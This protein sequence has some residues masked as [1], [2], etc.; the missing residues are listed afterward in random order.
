MRYCNW[1]TKRFQGGQY[2]KQ[3][4]DNTNTV[5]K[6]LCECFR[7]CSF[8]VYLCPNKWTSLFNENSFMCI[9]GHW[10]D[11][12]QKIQKRFIAFVVFNEAHNTNTSEDDS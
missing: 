5:E 12:L 8:S 9:K 7:T 11:D 4:L 2:K 6:Q 3:T 1:C 10:I